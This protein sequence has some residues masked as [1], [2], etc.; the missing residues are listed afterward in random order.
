MPVRTSIHQ[1][2]RVR[3][4]IGELLNLAVYTVNCVGTLTAMF[5]TALKQAIE[6][7][8]RQGS[9]GWYIVGWNGRPMQAHHNRLLYG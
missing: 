4:V 7:A 9:G 8:P 3:A 5:A 2:W 1:A 6:F